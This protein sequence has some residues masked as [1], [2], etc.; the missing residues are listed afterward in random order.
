MPEKNYK[1]IQLDPKYKPKQNETYMCPLQLAYFYQLLSARKDELLNELSNIKLRDKADDL[2]VG[3]ELDNSS[4]EQE[5]TMNIKISERQNNLLRKINFAL[6][7][8]DNKT[9]GFSAISGD[10]IG[11]KRLFA[12]PLATVTIE[13]QEEL[14]RKGL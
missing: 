2:G 10:E 14:E 8:I 4:F 3:D 6:D 9:F 5:L 13:E 11:L 12:R 1:T 7:R